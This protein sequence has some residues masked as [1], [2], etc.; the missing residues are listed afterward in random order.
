MLSLLSAAAWHIIISF[1]WHTLLTC[2]PKHRQTDKMY[3][4]VC[5]NCECWLLGYSY[6]S[7]DVNRWGEK[8]KKHKTDHQL[9]T[10]IYQISV[11]KLRRIPQNMNNRMTHFEL[12]LHLILSFLL[13][14][15]LFFLSLQA[16]LLS[17]PHLFLFMV[18]GARAL[19]PD[20]RRAV[21]INR[22][23]CIWNTWCTP[24]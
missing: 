13:L 22:K 21:T 18:V 11:E 15:L 16:L 9:S 24:V 8:R 1:F 3:S 19:L 5:V 7:T 12:L 10:I 20:R 2:H 17:L 6:K 4:D 23:V 14:F